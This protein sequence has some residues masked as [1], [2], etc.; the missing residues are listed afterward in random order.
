MFTY[1]IFILIYSRELVKA[2]STTTRS[3]GPLVSHLRDLIETKNLRA[4][5]LAVQGFSSAQS[6][7]GIGTPL[8]AETANSPDGLALKIKVCP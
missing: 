8:V 3:F 6:S 7:P 1:L 2:F 5:G 4:L